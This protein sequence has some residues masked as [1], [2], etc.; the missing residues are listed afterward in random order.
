MGRDKAL[1][2]FRGGPLAESVARA[3]DL[4]AG[5]ATLVGNPHLYRHLGFPAIPDAYPGQG[6]LGG[7]LTALAHT[8][9]HWNLLAACDMPGLSAEFLRRLLDAAERSDADALLPAGPSGRPEPL[10][11]VYHRRILAALETAFEHG[12]RQVTAALHEVRAAVLPILEVAPFQNV[13]TPE[14]WAAHVP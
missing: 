11:A 6:P 14:E 9:A 4:A 3:V 1:L 7:I 13:N 5:S 2:P 12:V 10:C 8:S